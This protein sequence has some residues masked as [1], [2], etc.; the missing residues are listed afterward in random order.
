MIA[1]FA[2]VIVLD[3]P[4]LVRTRPVEKRQ[5]AGERHG[6]AERIVTSRRHHRGARVLGP[7]AYVEAAL[8]DGDRHGLEAELGESAADKDIARL[9]DQHLVTALEDA[10]DQKLER[11]AC[12]TGD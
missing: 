10:L 5:A 1:I 6:H 9:F 12:P 4:A 2:V 3:D 11:F 8:I 7:F